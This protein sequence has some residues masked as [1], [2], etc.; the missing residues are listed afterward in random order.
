VIADEL[1]A[2]PPEKRTAATKE[3]AA[4]AAFIF[5][6]TIRMTCVIAKM[7]FLSAWSESRGHATM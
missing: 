3:P 2:A 6:M 1:S 4:G 7:G 5:F